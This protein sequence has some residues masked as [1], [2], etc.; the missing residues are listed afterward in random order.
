[1]TQLCSCRLSCKRSEMNLL[2][3][4]MS[5]GVHQGATCS[6]TDPGDIAPQV[7]ARDLGDAHAADD[8]RLAY[9]EQMVKGLFWVWAQKSEQAG[10][11]SRPALPSERCRASFHELS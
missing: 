4:G 5:A 2:R 11:D 7:Y 10:P 6:A 9:A 1:M 3:A 8:R